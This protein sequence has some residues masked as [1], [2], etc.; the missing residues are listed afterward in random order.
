MEMIKSGKALGI[1]NLTSFPCQKLT[2]FLL[3][4]EGWVRLVTLCY[5]NSRAACH[6]IYGIGPV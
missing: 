6:T 5:T 2:S 4:K 1:Q 3:F